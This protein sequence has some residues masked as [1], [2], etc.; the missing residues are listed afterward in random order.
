[1][2]Q[3]TL[4]LKIKLKKVKQFNIAAHLKG[5][6]IKEEENDDEIPYHEKMKFH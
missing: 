6:I 1:M 4:S 5:I 2:F 3:F